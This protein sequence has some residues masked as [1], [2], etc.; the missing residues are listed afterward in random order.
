M[1]ISD[2]SSDVCSSDL[3]NPEGRERHEDGDRDDGD[4]E[5]G[6]NDR[7]HRR[8]ARSRLAHGILVAIV[9]GLVDRIAVE[10]ELAALPD[11]PAQ[12]RSTAHLQDRG[13]QVREQA[14][15]R[16][17]E[18]IGTPGAGEEGVRSEERRRGK[19]WVRTC[20]SRWAPE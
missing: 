15:P 13:G 14:R 9:C 2:W 7:K 1:R 12:Q 10:R 11:G 8:N 19:G 6:A 5:E 3:I 18:G 16:S 17:G 20:R 4:E